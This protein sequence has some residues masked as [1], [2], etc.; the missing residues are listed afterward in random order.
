[1]NEWIKIIID[2]AEFWYNSNKILGHYNNIKM[3]RA[4]KAYAHLYCVL[5][6]DENGNVIDWDYD[7][8]DY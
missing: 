1:M 2:G 7:D 8:G 3:Y 5:F 6:I 4:I